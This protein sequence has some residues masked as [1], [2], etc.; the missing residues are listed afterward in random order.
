[1]T[2][3]TDNAGVTVIRVDRDPDF[4]KDDPKALDGRS[5]KTRKD[6]KWS[7][8]ERRFAM[9]YATGETKGNAAASA[10]VAGYSESYVLTKAHKLA[11]KPYIIAAVNAHIVANHRPGPDPEIESMQARL[12][13]IAHFDIG[14]IFEMDERTPGGIRMRDLTQIDTSCLKE[15]KVKVTTT[16]YTMEVKGYD[17]MRS[18][19]MFMKSK[20]QFGDKDAGRGKTI[21]VNIIH[22]HLPEAPLV[23]N[24]DG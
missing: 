3:K 9:A 1:M 6:P 18:I 4:P 15:I 10:R 12:S 16:G 11:K 22:G 14:S 5:L 19:E 13:K 7:D 2:R 21:T 20:G 17:A 23:V 8:R 24:P